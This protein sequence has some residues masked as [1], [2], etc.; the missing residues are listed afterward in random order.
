MGALTKAPEAFLV[1]LNSFGPTLTKMPEALTKMPEAW[2]LGPGGLGVVDGLGWLK[3]MP[4]A[5]Y[6]DTMLETGYVGFVLL[7]FIFVT[8]HA[9]APLVDRDPVR[10]WLVLSLV[11]D[12]IG[13]SFLESMWLRGGVRVL[14]VFVLM[15]AFGQYWQPI[16]PG[17]RSPLYWEGPSTSVKPVRINVLDRDRR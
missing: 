15:V 17:G 4:H 7:V 5:Y 13:T 3:T 8:L 12:E 9:A 2:Q 11:L 14:V 1:F 10:A 6:L 16:R